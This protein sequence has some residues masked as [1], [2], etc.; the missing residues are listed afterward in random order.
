MKFWSLEHQYNF[1]DIW[2]FL[3]NYVFP[4]ALLVHFYLVSHSVYLLCVITAK[5]FHSLN[6]YMWTWYKWIC[7]TGKENAQ[8]TKPLL[9]QFPLPLVY[10][11]W[12]DISATELHQNGKKQNLN[13]W[14]NPGTHSE[15]TCIKQLATNIL[16][17][18]TNF[19]A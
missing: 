19:W 9:F 2:P 4:S 15:P 18:V 17:T 13:R 11:N 12:L 1:R 14:Q 6:A 5:L 3:Y 10:E 16:A 7:I 8:L